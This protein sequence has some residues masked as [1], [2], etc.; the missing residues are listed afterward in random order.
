M[1]F[2]A[3]IFDMDGVLLDSERIAL[4]TFS[5]ACETF[6]V[7]VDPSLYLSC[8]GTNNEKTKEILLAGFPDPQL[9]EKV[10]NLWFEKYR[11]RAFELP[12]PLKQGVRRL[13]ERIDAS[14]R[15]MAVAT[16]TAYQSAVQKLDNAGIKDYFS[17]IVG[18]DQIQHSKPDPEIYNKTAVAL[19][20]E[21]ER[22]LALED[23]ENGVRSATAAG[24][25]VIQI[26]D[27]VPPTADLNSLGHPIVESLDEVWAYIR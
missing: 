2:K 12:V 7:T 19:G 20:V 21:S 17:L 15:P 1:R 16:S 22:C 8:V 24:M 25:V 4:E 5:Q 13:L 14:G 26:P 23:S 3:I 18:G 27:L 11:K 9:F 6:Q 10:R